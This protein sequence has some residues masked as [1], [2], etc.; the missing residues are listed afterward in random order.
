MLTS[1]LP[2]AATVLSLAVLETLLSIDN[3]VVLALIARELPPK[4][5]NQAL[6]YGLV[7]AVVLRILAV[8]FATLLVQHAWVK[9]LGGS[10]L[11]WLA[12]RYFFK[13]GSDSD[14]KP[15]RTSSHFWTVVFWIEVTD[16]V[17]AIDSILAAVAITQDYWAIVVGGLLGVVAIRFAAG[18][19]IKLLQQYPRLETFAYLLV[20][21][22][23]IK[24]LY[25]VAYSF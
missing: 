13:K 5:Q 6:R 23:G 8:Y 11:L 1:I 16:L 3:A 15:K 9:A 25:Q 21:G 2:F 7:G 24:V 10:Y 18:G 19:M 20:A 12:I 22:V 17:F 4:E 14:S